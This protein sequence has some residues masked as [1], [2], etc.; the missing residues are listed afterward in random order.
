MTSLGSMRWSIEVVRR[1][2]TG[3]L[4]FEG[5]VGHTYT[6]IIT[7]RAACDTSKGV[8]EFNRVNV[9]GTATHVFTIRFTTIPFDIRDRVRDTLGNLYMILSIENVNEA[10]QWFKITCARTGKDDRVVT[11]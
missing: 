2:I 7:T 11:T 10:R 8:T 5:S 3:P 9:E 1:V 4:P 6:P